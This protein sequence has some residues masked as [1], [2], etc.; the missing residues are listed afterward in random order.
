MGHPNVSGTPPARHRSSSLLLLALQGIFVF[1]LTGCQ[2]PSPAMKFIRQADQLH[3][4]AL[5]STLII[6]TDL[7]EY[8]QM[9]GDR[10]AA[11]AKTALPGKVDAAFIARVRCQLVNSDTIN[12]FS[13]GGTHIYVTNGLFQKCESEDDLASAVAHAYAHLINLDIEATK[14]KPDTGLTPAMIVWQFVINRY[15]REQERRADA[16]ALTLY[17]QAGYD[18]THFP[19]LLERMESIAGG[20]VAAD[21]ESLPA[22]AFALRAAAGEKSGAPH[23][24]P[25]AD[26]RTFLEVLRPEAAKFRETVPSDAQ[27]ML[28]AFPNCILSG[29]TREQQ[30]AQ[31]RLRPL[32]PPA[33]PPIEPS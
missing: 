23:V 5:S 17:T 32:P 20:N 4:E 22:R 16:L 13:T 28:R 27:I 9:V 29:D 19:L 15:T 7:N 31:Q 3:G 11:A 14:M 1:V 10:I 18:P 24:L 33:H 25:V 21:R 12:A 8:L 26:T 30:E 2:A 6:D